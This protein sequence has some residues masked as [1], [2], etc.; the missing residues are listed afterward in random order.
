MRQISAG[1]IRFEVNRHFWRA[2]VHPR[3]RP[4]FW[5]S[6]RAN[7][8]AEA[9][10]LRRQLKPSP[11]KVKLESGAK[12]QRPLTLSLSLS[13]S[14]KA[15]RLLCAQLSLERRRRRR[16]RRPRQPRSACRLPAAAAAS[17]SQRADERQEREKE[18]R[19]W[20]VCGC[21]RRCCCGDGRL[22]PTTGFGCITA[23][24]AT[25]PRLPSAAGYA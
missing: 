10:L 15:V 20:R 8:G 5:R 9:N 25:A 17:A 18:L 19:S 12:V 23:H 1:A 16:Q 3:A 11:S 22:K 24:S 14:Q 7:G 13:L 4:L 2:S 6:A 21:R